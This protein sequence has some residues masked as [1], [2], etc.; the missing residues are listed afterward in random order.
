MG[1]GAK[2]TDKKV[3]D[4]SRIG[5]SLFVPRP[6]PSLSVPIPG[7]RADGGSGWRRSPIG[8]VLL[9]GLS[10]I[11]PIRPDD[12]GSRGGERS[13]A[14]DEVDLCSPCSE[15]CSSIRPYP[16]LF[17][18]DELSLSVPRPSL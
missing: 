2:P 10:P 1:S 7:D 11:R 15:R 5:P 3:T 14:R 18:P 6:Y 16:S 8:K 9:R 12:S 4:S 17:V 13:E